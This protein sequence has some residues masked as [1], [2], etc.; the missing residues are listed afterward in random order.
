MIVMEM[1]CMET[2]Y[3]DDDDDKMKSELRRE[4]DESEK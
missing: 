4:R 2:R 1:Q 3:H